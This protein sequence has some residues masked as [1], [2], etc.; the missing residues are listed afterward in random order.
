VIVN[1]L[2]KGKVLA[3]CVVDPYRIADL[4]FDTLRQLSQRAVDFFVLLP[5]HMD[6]KRGTLRSMS[7]K[8][9]RRS[10]KNE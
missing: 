9:I 2:P 8:A 3:F 10:K 7:R 6:V 5:S 4:A 1:A